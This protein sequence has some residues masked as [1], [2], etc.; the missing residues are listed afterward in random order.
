[1]LMRF[2]KELLIRPN[3]IVQNYIYIVN[4]LT[5]DGVCSSVSKIITRDKYIVVDP[6]RNQT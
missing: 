2:I 4:N 3:A 1:M 5:S 6:G